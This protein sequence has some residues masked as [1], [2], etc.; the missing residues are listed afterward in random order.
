MV[1]R[2]IKTVPLRLEQGLSERAYALT[3]KLHRR[4]KRAVLQGPREGLMKLPRREFLRL[5]AGAAALGSVSR[6]AWAQT[7]PSRI[8]SF[9][10]QI[11]GVHHTQV[12]WARKQARSQRG[13]LGTHQ[14]MLTRGAAS[15]G[16]PSGEEV[17]D[18]LL[19][20]IGC[21]LARGAE[22]SA[23]ELYRLELF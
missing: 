5:A 15:S 9:A 1:C 3:E 13:L 11:S 22:L 12:R 4:A 10:L 2:A 8:G 18:H 21:A 14:S 16:T 20:G 17:V 7:Y 6:I 23:F 19:E